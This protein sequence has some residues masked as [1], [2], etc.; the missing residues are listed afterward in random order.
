MVLR[1]KANLLTSHCFMGCRLLVALHPNTFEC[2][3]IPSVIT[4]IK[5]CKV[6]IPLQ[7]GLHIER[8]SPL[9]EMIL[10]F[11]IIIPQYCN[12]IFAFHMHTST[13]YALILN[14]FS[15]AIH[16]NTRFMV[17]SLNQNLHF[18]IHCKNFQK[19]Y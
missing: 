8:D 12:N 16:Q 7:L 18:K 13:I 14:T 17:I 15:I 19:Q 9:V 10:F 4:Q 3:C 5:K 2:L 6:F 1:K 11:C